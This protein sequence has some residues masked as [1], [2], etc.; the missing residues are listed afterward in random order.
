MSGGTET[1]TTLRRERPRGY[2]GASTRGTVRDDHSR[3]PD[4]WLS[5]DERI[6]HLRRPSCNIPRAYTAH[7]GARAAPTHPGVRAPF[8]RADGGFARKISIRSVDLAFVRIF[9]ESRTTSDQ[10]SPFASAL[11]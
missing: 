8:V 1:I 2:V 10:G 6:M 11:P 4:R 3:G 5:R 9:A 7:A